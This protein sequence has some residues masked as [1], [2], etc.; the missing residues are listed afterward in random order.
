MTDIYGTDIKDSF[1]FSN[2]DIDIISGIENLEQS[3]INILN[4]KLGFYDWCYE[5]YGSNLSEIFGRQNDD[6][7]LEYLRI[8]IEYTVKKNPRVKDISVNCT[9]ENPQTV[10]AELQI[11]PIGENEMVTINL[12]INEDFKVQINEEAK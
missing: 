7:S 12:I 1:S 5:N 11:L 4:T 8:E 10:S 3:I 9:K 6:N 2:G